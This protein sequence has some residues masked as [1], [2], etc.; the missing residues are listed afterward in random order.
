MSWLD[1]EHSLPVLWERIKKL[2]KLHIDNKENP[3][4]VTKA[5]V[6]LG[7]V[8][9][10]A[11]KDK[12][13]AEATKATQDGAG[14]VITDTYL[15][16]VDAPE[17]VAP[18]ERKDI[19]SRI[20][21]LSAAIASG[22]PE[23]YDF[24]EGYYFNGASKYEYLLSSYCH[25]HGQVNNDA[26]IKDR[27]WGVIVNTKKTH[28]WNSSNKTTGGY[29][30]SELDAY[31][32]DEVLTN[33]KSDLTALFG[34]DW[35]NHLIANNKLLSNAV[36]ETHYNRFGTASGAASSWT[37]FNGRYIV[38]PSEIE[39][40]GSIAW[41]SSGYDTGEACHPL[42]AFQRFRFNELL[43]N[44]YPW[45]RDVASAS[46]ACNAHSNGFAHYRAVSYAY[47]VLGLI[48]IK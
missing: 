45:L 41:S 14:N 12:K 29:S 37:W 24:R 18:Y 6:G 32:Q 47:Y 31:L 46:E 28:A 19:T 4:G 22:N 44:I 3:H 9:N 40:Y 25:F 21:E 23:K 17:A 16:K 26:V 43:G 20:G 30:A 7:S 10:T 35:S 8:D 36:D 15:K 38:A 48:A 27:H 2:I 34:D 33:V 1:N 11:D 42:Q 5:Q 13:V 39:I